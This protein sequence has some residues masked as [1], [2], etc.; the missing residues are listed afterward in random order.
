MSDQT[1]KP[2]N[3]RKDL[4]QNFTVEDRQIEAYKMDIQGYKN[5]EIAK[6]LGVSISTIEKDL[7]KF[8]GEITFKLRNME[9]GG[10]NHALYDAILQFNLVQ[11]ELWQTCS[12][13]KDSLRK[14]KL[15]DSI[16]NNAVNKFEMLKNAPQIPS[17]RDIAMQEFVQSI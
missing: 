8:K 4:E 12:Q 15:L 14:Q 6:K 1:D 16:A 17:A 3:N 10:L 11:D 5:L 9:N 2:E 7:K 13:E